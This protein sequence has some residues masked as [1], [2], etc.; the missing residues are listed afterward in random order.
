MSDRSLPLATVKGKPAGD[1]PTS[2]SPS[3][4]APDRLE[5]SKGEWLTLGKGGRKV[6][7]AGT[8]SQKVS[9]ADTDSVKQKKKDQIQKGRSR[10]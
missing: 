6:Q 10:L 4:T 2:T 1:K 9:S 8:Q 7:P 5:K 3:E